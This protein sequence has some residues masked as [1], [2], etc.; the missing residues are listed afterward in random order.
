MALT[1]GEREADD[2][3]SASDADD[4]SKNM[5]GTF[6]NNTKEGP[7]C[8]E[9]LYSAWRTLPPPA[10]PM[11]A[12]HW[13]ASEQTAGGEC[14][15]TPPRERHRLTSESGEGASAAARGHSARA[16]K[17][18]PPPLLR[19]R[20]RLLFG[21]QLVQLAPRRRSRNGGHVAAVWPQPKERTPRSECNH[22]HARVCDQQHGRAWEKVL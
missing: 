7:P 4:L 9:V 11:A 12:T 18:L 8:T 6:K 14:R 2:G 19:R 15:S 3:C 20:A 16:R 22:G 17:S 1:W 5:I 21:V 10:G 13:S